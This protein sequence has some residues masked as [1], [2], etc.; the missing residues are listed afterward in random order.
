MSEPDHVTSWFL[1]E[2]C[3]VRRS[4][5]EISSRALAFSSF[6]LASLEGRRVALLLTRS[7]GGSVAV[8][9]SGSDLVAAGGAVGWRVSV[10][11]LC[12][13]EVTGLMEG[14][15]VERTGRVDFGGLEELEVSFLL[16][17]SQQSLLYPGIE[18]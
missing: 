13:E 15:G 2:D 3:L 10:L 6:R 1:L 7:V 17:E 11:M 16:Q 5:V 4:E 18:Q 8:E 9:W 14:S 12:E